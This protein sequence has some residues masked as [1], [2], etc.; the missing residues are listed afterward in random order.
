[1]FSLIIIKYLL[2]AYSVKGLVQNTKNIKFRTYV[3]KAFYLS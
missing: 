2:S 1:M 3:L